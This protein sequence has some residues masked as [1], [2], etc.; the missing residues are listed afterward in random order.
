[1]FDATDRPPD[2]A[3][4]VAFPAERSEARRQQ[5]AYARFKEAL[6]DLSSEPSAV[7][8]LRYLAAS[9]SLEESR[10][11]EGPSRGAEVGGAFLPPAA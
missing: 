3:R 5:R 11:V 7:N 8:V 9:R 6:G 2:S 10:R 4:I 1:M